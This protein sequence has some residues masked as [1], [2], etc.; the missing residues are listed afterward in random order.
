[1]VMIG[2][3]I[4]YLSIIIYYRHYPNSIGGNCSIC[5]EDIKEKLFVAYPPCWHWIHSECRREYV[6][7]GHFTCPICRKTYGDLDMT[8]HNAAMD[9][10]I[11]SV[12]MPE[13]YKDWQ[14][15]VCH[16]FILSPS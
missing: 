7:R 4:I 15:E 1:M 9:R 13:D 10:M 5:N 3:S 12:V 2:G 8:N 11:A 16:I 6:L 14:R